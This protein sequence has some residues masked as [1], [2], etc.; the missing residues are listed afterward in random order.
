M[1]KIIKG[2]TTDNTMTPSELYA[3]MKEI[4]HF[5]DQNNLWRTKAR[6]KP[7]DKKTRTKIL[8]LKFHDKTPFFLACKKGFVHFVN[9]FLDE[10]DVDIE[11]RSVYEVAEDRSKH[12]VTPLWC[13]AVANHVDVV[14]SLIQHGADVNGMSDTQS[15][16]VRSACYMSN[17]DIVKLLVEN[18]ADIHK[19][20]IN[21]GT[22][23]INSVQS[24]ELCTFLIEHGAKVNAQDNS[25]NL[26]L[27]Y[28]IREG[29]LETVQLLVERKSDVSL[30]NEIGDDALQTASLRGFEDIVEY[31][32]VKNNPDKDMIVRAYELMGANY[33]DEK[34]DIPKGL[35]FWR[36]A[37]RLRRQFASSVTEKSLLVNKSANP[38]Y[39]NTIEF[40]DENDL[41]VV[42]QNP[43]AIYMQ[44]LLIR[45]RILGPTHKDTTFGLMYRGAVYADTH[46]Y[47]RCIDIWTYVLVIRHTHYK[48][49]T[50][51]TVFIHLLAITRLF[52]E[53]WLEEQVLPISSR[54]SI[55]F[56]DVYKVLTIAADQIENGIRLM[57]DSSDSNFV[58]YME[59]FHTVLLLF[60]HVTN[61]LCALDLKDDEKFIFRKLVHKLISLKPLGPKKETLLHLAL[62]KESS[63]VDHEQCSNLPNLPIVKI[64]IECGINVNATDLYGN[65]ALHVLAESM[66]ND[67][68]AGVGNS[69]LSGIATYLLD[70]GAHVDA[71]NHKLKVAYVELIKQGCPVA[72]FDYLSLKCLAAAAIRKHQL[73]FS[74]AD[75][76]RNLKPFI[77]MH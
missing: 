17:I 13:A 1:L 37:L 60:L 11:Q 56:A 10:C 64:L 22:C 38:A 62:C 41:N 55:Q 47:Q 57:P 48:P 59:F 51:E 9:Y 49:I 61:L 29:R 12:M 74:D 71:C 77:E 24:V 42:A 20:N 53:V 3:C 46:R 34:H 7:L 16:P 5:V 50:Q 70:H 18:R 58:Q 25:G 14:K 2:C 66:Q 28:A 73:T 15:T 68:V 39:E 76:P 45:E 75:I 32:I 65:T 54:T 6:L 52:W 63:T 36:E 30:K 35:S 19:P 26:A 72:V 4:W 33:V 69:D 23:L 27:H 8:S 21:G 67:T 43:D 40:I 31:L 44:A